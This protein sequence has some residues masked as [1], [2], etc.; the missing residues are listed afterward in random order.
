MWQDLWQ[1]LP[2]S[3]DPV[4]FSLGP[5]TVRWY[6]LMYIVAFAIVYALTLY[7]LKQEKFAG[8]LPKSDKERRELLES[9]LT[10]G[11]FGVILGGRLGYFLFYETAIFW[12]KPWLIFW[13]FS[14]GEFVGLS[15]MSFHG[16]LIGVI[17]ALLIFSRLHKQKF[18]TVAELLLPAI[19]LG[20]FFGRVGNYLNGE[21]WGRA[22]ASPIGQLFV[23]AGDLPRHPSQLYEAFFEGLVLFGLLWL[24][25]K[26]LSGANLL[27]MFLA[28][29]GFVRFVIE[30]FREPDAHLGLIGGFLSQ[31]QILCLLMIIAG[32]VVW[33]LGRRGRI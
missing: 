31:G 28:G 32:A 21:L 4:A 9:V 19:P 8:K 16:G 1:T 7:R 3:F 2:L 18:W 14:N 22:T 10:Y 25:R 23:G 13:P 11:V 27:A 29:Y 26:K 24:L 20:Y 6:G 15:G 33:Y 5:I 17:L 30:Y 12:T